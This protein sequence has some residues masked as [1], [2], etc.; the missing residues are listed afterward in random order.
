MHDNLN[1][2]NLAILISLYTGIRI[3]E[4]CALQWKDINFQERTMSISKTVQRIITNNCNVK[5][6]L[7]VNT[8]KTE[9]SMRIIPLPD[10]LLR[11][12][13]MFMSNNEHFILTDSIKPKDPRSVEKY[14]TNLLKKNNLPILNFHALR[15]TFATRSREAGMD[16]KILSKILGHSSYHTTQEIYVHETMDF[17]RASMNTLYKYMISPKVR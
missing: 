3:G 12:L 4:L 14:F 8:P 2:R 6:K 9:S 16:I 15:H 13:K 7:T 17:M 5:T 11:I 1:L 10:R